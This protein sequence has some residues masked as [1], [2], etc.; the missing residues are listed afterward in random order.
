MQCTCRFLQESTQRLQDAIKKGLEVGRLWTFGDG[1]CMAC[2]K[3]SMGHRTCM[4]DPE[5]N[6]KENVWEVPYLPIDP[7]EPAVLLVQDG[8]SSATHPHCFRGH[9]STL[10]SHHPGEQP[11]WEGGLLK[12]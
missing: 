5:A 2:S 9:R 8:C 1:E 11:E 3:R 10:R 12:L 4:S 6:K 7:Q